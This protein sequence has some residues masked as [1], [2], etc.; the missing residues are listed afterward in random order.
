MCI[1][2]FPLFNCL[3]NIKKMRSNVGLV[4]KSTGFQ[5]RN[6][7]FLLNFSEL[8]LFTTYMDKLKNIIFWG[9][10]WG[11]LEATLGWAL[12]LIHFKGE[13][14][15][16]YPFGL[17][18]MMMAAK[19]TGQMS[20]VIKVAGV[21]SLVKLINLFMLPA[22]PP[23]HVINPAAAIFLEGLVTW[24][25]VVAVR[26][27]PLLWRL[28]IPMG[29]LMVLTSIFIFRGWQILMDAYVTYNPSVHKPFDMGVIF[30]W[31]WR[32]LVQGAMLAA[33]VYLVGRMSFRLDIGRWTKQLAIPFLLAAILLN[34][35]I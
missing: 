19:Q 9:A 4:T 12:H 18:C 14:L 13:V 31:G 25:F 20:T 1:E 23:Y 15:I 3:I 32:S 24:G 17:A 5:G 27:H 21:A 11:I 28:S 34:T 26:K 10:C 30:Q 8:I 33:V 29:A 7:V 22:V 35:L 16:L 6:I 2:P